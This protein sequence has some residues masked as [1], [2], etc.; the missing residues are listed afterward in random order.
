M[1]EWTA[2]T[3]WAVY[4]YEN[5]ERDHNKYT[6]VTYFTNLS[7]CGY[8]I[9]NLSIKW[10]YVKVMETAFKNSSGVVYGL[11]KPIEIAESV[12]IK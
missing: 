9:I 5:Q 3:V 4:I 11:G 1:A 10:N 6:H 12:L 2:I 8:Y 7:E